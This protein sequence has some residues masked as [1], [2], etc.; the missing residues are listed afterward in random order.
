YW[1]QTPDPEIAAREAALFRG[2]G[3]LIAVSRSLAEVAEAAHGIPAAA[4]DV[5]H[6]GIDPA[7]LAGGALAPEACRRLRRTIA[8]DD[9]A[10]VRFAGRLNPMKGVPALLAAAAE[11]VAARPQVRYVLAGELDSRAFKPTLDAILDRHPELA[12]RTAFLGRVPRRQ[13]LM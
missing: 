9:E 4:F 10:I 8:A 13:L 3:P 1:G 7:A 12:R 11:V 2:A 6:N 5:I